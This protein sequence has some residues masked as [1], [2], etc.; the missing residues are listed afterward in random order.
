MT[1]KQWYRSLPDELQDKVAYNCNA[2]NKS[3]RFVQWYDD[4]RTVD[5]G[6]AFSWRHTPEGFDFWYDINRKLGQDG[7]L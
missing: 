4:K 7:K 5:L 2:L 1:N 6:G 3:Y